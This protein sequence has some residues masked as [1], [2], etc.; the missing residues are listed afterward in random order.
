MT[1]N[2]TIAATCVLGVTLFLTLWILP[3]VLLITKA[4]L[5]GVWEFLISDIV[6]AWFKAWRELFGIEREE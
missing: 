3:H 6:H 4:F 1:L 5:S 2:N